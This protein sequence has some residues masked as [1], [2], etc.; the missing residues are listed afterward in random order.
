[1]LRQVDNVSKRAIAKTSALSPLTHRRYIVMPRLS[2]TKI[3]DRH[4]P[5]SE[6]TTS[7]R[8]CYAA[9]DKSGKGFSK[10]H[11]VRM[12]KSFEIH[13]EVAF[14]EREAWPR[15]KT[16][17]V[18]TSEAE[19]DGDREVGAWIGFDEADHAVAANR[20]LDAESLTEAQ[21]RVQ[22]SPRDWDQDDGAP[23]LGR[24]CRDEIAKHDRFGAAERDRRADAVEVARERA[25]HRGS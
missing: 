17:E 12:L 21:A 8:E 25:R 4:K 5:A 20:R 22:K 19:P 15:A 14:C 23:L 16:S 6:F 7:A 24:D 11:G 1:L 9:I 10:N 2:V 18:E 13:R 3:T